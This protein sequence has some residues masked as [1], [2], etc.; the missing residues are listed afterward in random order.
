[1]SKTGV[2]LNNP[3][4]PIPAI[5][6]G[7]PV[8]PSFPDAV[9]DT[10]TLNTSITRS[11]LASAFLEYFKFHIPEKEVRL[12]CTG[13]P[14][15]NLAPCGSAFPN[16]RACH[17]TDIVAPIHIDPGPPENCPKLENQDEVGRKGADLRCSQAGD[18]VRHDRTLFQYFEMRDV[19]MDWNGVV[20][21]SSMHFFRH[22]CFSDADL[23]GC[24]VS[25][26][27]SEILTPPLSCLCLPVTSLPC[28]STQFT[29]PS[30][31]TTVQ[32][33][34]RMVSMLYTPATSSPLSVFPPSHHKL[35][36]LPQQQHHGAARGAH[37]EHAVHPGPWPPPSPFLCFSPPNINQFTY[38]S[39]NTTVQRAGRK[40]SMLYTLATSYPF[41]C[42]SSSCPSPPSPLL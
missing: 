11:H 38:P 39:A 22:G 12:Q 21:N 7:S 9:L 23:V 26:L 8:L 16:L 10:T 6:E 35:V 24:M 17:R 40:V 31:N 30:S 29:Y 4:L 13:G 41:F 20:F 18:Y 2:E 19:M 34:E 3:N 15:P 28:T 36:H 33:V 27:Y 1:M 42:A 32:R 25:V 37:G 14:C 5:P